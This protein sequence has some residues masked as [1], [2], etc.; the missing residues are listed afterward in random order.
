MA[1]VQPIAPGTNLPQLARTLRRVHSAVL[2]GQSPEVAPRPLVQRS[3][4]RVISYGLSVDGTPRVDPLG[5]E[6]LEARRAASGLVGVVDEL[7]QLIGDGTERAHMLLVVTDA[8]GVILWRDGTAAVR[9]HADSFGFAEGAV[10]TESRVGTN[11]IGTALAEAAPVQLFAAEHY[12]QAQHPW[13]C[14]ATPIHDPRDGRL[15]GI[16]DVSGPAL[17][18]HPAIRALVEATRRLAEARLM[19]QH[20]ASLESLRRLAEPIITTCSGPA[21][22]VDDNGWVALSRGVGVQRRLAAPGADRLVHVPGVGMCFTERLGQGWLLRPHQISG[23]RLS[24]R[25]TLGRHPAVEVRGA[26]EPWRRGI[27]S[28]HA[29]ILLHLHRAGPSGLNAATLSAA[30]FGDADH[31]VTVRAEVSRLR[32]VL[33]AMIE[34]NPYRLA[35]GITVE[36]DPGQA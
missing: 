4:E 33:G 25:L 32:R 15:L 13:Y 20:Q 31:V 23:E 5:S 27:T 6:E 29:E 11:A 1:V 17:T 22:V 16:I 3:W 36:V 8:D 21:V 34:G 14:T 35:S 12:E 9:R 10:W 24:L 30:L 18:L 26:G 28:R 7:A 2:D 19:T